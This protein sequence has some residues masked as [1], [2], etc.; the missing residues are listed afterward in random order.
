MNRFALPLFLF[1]T[2][3]LAIAWSIGY[4]LNGRENPTDASPDLGWWLT[5]PLALSV[6]AAHH[7]ADHLHLRPQWVKSPIQVQDAVG[8]GRAVRSCV[9]PARTGP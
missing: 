5:R 9:A 3:G 1:H 4:L 6:A 7:A 2:S 8:A